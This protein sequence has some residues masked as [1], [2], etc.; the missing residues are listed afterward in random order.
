MLLFVPRV[1]F[2]GD[3]D[4]TRCLGGALSDTRPALTSEPPSHSHCQCRN[5]AAAAFL[6]LT[7]AVLSPFL[8]SSPS[9]QAPVLDPGEAL[10]VKHD[11]LLLQRRKRKLSQ[12]GRVHAVHLGREQQ[13]H[14]GTATSSMSFSVS[15]LG[16]VP[17]RDGIHQSESPAG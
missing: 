15:R 10:V 1:L 13:L 6:P 3:A 7:M 14:T 12:L 16:W 2:L 4:T 17:R 8:F 11:A 5:H 9:D